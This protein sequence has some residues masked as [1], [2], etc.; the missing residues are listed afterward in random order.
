MKEHKPEHQHSCGIDA[1]GRL[2]LLVAAVA[3]FLGVALGAFGAHG[4]QPLL[5]QRGTA[6]AWQTGIQYWFYHSL[7]L[8]AVG[9][10]TP[11]GSALR[12]RVSIVWLTG[13]LIFS[14]SLFFL[15]TTGPRW[16]GAITP[17]GGV[18]FLAGWMLLFLG[19]LRKPAHPEP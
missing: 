4:L 12:R 17:I 13:M 10:A 8:L 5:E 14:G 16:L 1:T 15:A 2:I 9:V 3:G 18:L 11:L 19:V 7:A 6:A